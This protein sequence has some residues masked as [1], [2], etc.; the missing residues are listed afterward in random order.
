MEINTATKCLAAVAHEG[1]LSLLRRLI[2]AGPEG[3]SA[4]ELARFAASSPTTV[5]AQLLVLSNAALVSS[6][7]EGRHVV[8]IAKFDTMR[9]LL[10]FLMLDCCGNSPDI[11]GPVVRACCP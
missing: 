11:C 9:V 4:G 5:S 2:Q 6:R 10:E 3:V 7:R 8:Y 1:R